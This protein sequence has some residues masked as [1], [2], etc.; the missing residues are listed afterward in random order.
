MI[1]RCRITGAAQLRYRELKVDET[2]LADF[3][4][5]DRFMTD[6]DVELVDGVLRACSDRFRR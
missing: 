6:R 2:L 5:K 1:R 4:A 3:M